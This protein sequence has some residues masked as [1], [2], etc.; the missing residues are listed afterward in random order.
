MTSLFKNMDAAHKRM[1]RN[2]VAFTD[3]IA[4]A[5]H[6]G[7]RGA[8]RHKHQ[9]IAMCVG[10]ARVVC[11]S[12]PLFEE[13][14]EAQCLQDN[15]SV[16]AATEENFTKLVPFAVVAR[17]FEGT[18]ATENRIRVYGY[19]TGYFVNKCIAV[20]HIPKRIEAMEGLEGVYEKVK[21]KKRQARD[22]TKSGGSGDS[23]SRALKPDKRESAAA[24]AARA[25]GKCEPVE[26]EPS[27]ASGEHL[28]VKWILENHLLIK[29]PKEEKE[30]YLDG[31]ARRGQRRQL[32]TT[33]GGRG[34]HNLHDWEYVYGRD[35]EA[36]PSSGED[37]DNEVDYEDEDAA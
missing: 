13:L 29:M 18:E 24:K 12:F 19:V 26:D 17:S 35:V 32:D 5:I 31:S 1:L 28:T 20:P 7:E 25:S 4:G 16:Q 21:A 14:R 10:I 34:A 11:E 37:N 27:D 23:E 30:R 22:E 3:A 33:Y 6:K 2:P 36:G 9:G 8:H 15:K